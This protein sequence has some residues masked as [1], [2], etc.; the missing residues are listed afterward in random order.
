[1]ARVRTLTVTA[2]CAAFGLAASCPWSPA[3]AQ[4][5]PT[6]MGHRQPKAADLPT[7]PSPKRTPRSKEDVAL[8]RALNNICKG[9]NPVI[10]VRNVPRYDVARTCP[11]A[12]GRDVDSCRKDEETARGNLQKQWTQFT[13]KARSDCVQTNEIGG[14][15]TY[16]QLIIC[17]KAAQIAPT[18]TQ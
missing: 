7:D 6:P 2:F 8:E 16:V 17:L 10:Q 14:R 9:C 5:A 13:A 4:A 15:P 1:M 18:L 3:K 12:S 11:A